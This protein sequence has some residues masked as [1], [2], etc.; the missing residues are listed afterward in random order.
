MCKGVIQLAT[1]LHPI[2]AMRAL[3]RISSEAYLTHTALRFLDLGSFWSSMG[4]NKVLLDATVLPGAG[5]FPV[6]EHTLARAGLQNSWC[7]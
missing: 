5:L 7:W 3:R 4:G 2:K 1:H 6:L